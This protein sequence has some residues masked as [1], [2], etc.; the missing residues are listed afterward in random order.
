MRSAHYT[1]E[2]IT[3]NRYCLMGRSEAR[4]AYLF[5][6]NVLKNIGKQNINKHDIG[7]CDDFYGEVNQDSVYGLM[8]L[9][10]LLPEKVRKI[11]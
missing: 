9:Y 10:T 2:M 4:L 1:R 8:P 11:I 3:I 5:M 7:I 6:L